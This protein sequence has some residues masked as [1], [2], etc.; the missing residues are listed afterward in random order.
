MG[1][2]AY[3]IA[4]GPLAGQLGGYNVKAVCGHD[5]CEEKIDRGMAYMCGDNPHGG[6]EDSCGLFFCDGHLA[7]AA[8]TQPHQRCMACSEA[9]RSDPERVEGR[10]H[11]ADHPNTVPT[12]DGIGRC[13]C[14]EVSYGRSPT[15]DPAAP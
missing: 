11:L 2:G 15:M 4:G 5:G 1:Y 13:E 8:I 9:I 3:E 10:C 6:G 14:G 7:F 12:P